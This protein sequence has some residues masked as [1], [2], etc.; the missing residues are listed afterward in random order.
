MRCHVHPES[1]GLFAC[2]TT[3]T[4]IGGRRGVPLKAIS[5]RSVASKRTLV[6]DRCGSAPGIGTFGGPYG[7]LKRKQTWKKPGNRSRPFGQQQ[8]RSGRSAA[9]ILSL[10]S[11]RRMTY[12]TWDQ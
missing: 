6:T 11:K 9:R 1:L 8:T 3:S 10:L 7:P 12:E 4:G 5:Y 2:K